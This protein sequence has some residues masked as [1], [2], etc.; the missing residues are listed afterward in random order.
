M[1]STS[2]DRHR[3]GLSITPTAFDVL[4][5]PVAELQYPGTAAAEWHFPQENATFHNPKKGT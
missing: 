4:L 2:A 1:V 3:F 5:R